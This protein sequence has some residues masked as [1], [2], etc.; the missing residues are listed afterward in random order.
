MKYEITYKDGSKD[1]I[2]TKKEL[3]AVFACKNEGQWVYSLTSVKNIQKRFEQEKK[4]NRPWL[5]DWHI[6]EFKKI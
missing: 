4:L 6:A 3:T 5:S 1:S 2:E